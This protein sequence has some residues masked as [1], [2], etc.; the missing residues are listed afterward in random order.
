MTASSNLWSPPRRREW[1]W[2]WPYVIRLSNATTDVFGPPVP[3]EKVRSSSSRSPRRLP[4][5]TCAR[6]ALTSRPRA[7]GVRWV[8]TLAPLSAPSQDEDR[9]RSATPFLHFCPKPGIRPKWP[10]QESPSRCSGSPRASGRLLP[11]TPARR[12]DTSRVSPAKPRSTSGC[13]APARST[14]CVHRATR[15]SARFWN[16]Q[17]RPA[18][19][20][21]ASFRRHCAAMRKTIAVVLIILALCAGYVVWPYASLIGVVRAAKAGDV[22]QLQQRV[23]FRALRRSLSYQVFETYAR[24]TGTRIDPAGI[25]IA[26]ATSFIDPM[27]EK[28]LS[29]A[30]LAELMRKGW[31]TEVLA[32]APAEIEGLDPNT[33]GNAWRLFLNS[34]YGIG[35]VRV[36]VP[37]SQPREKQFRVE[38]ALERWTWKLA[39]LTLPIELQE[40]L[41][42]EL[43]KQQGKDG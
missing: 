12:P 8:P 26:A 1:E 16:S 14:G 40:R 41:A 27:I 15:N 18:S 19:H 10:K 32:E 3:R 39:G 25:T 23:N 30:T 20:N 31:P 11:S 4:S 7:L 29:P 5:H 28:L 6:P 38:L 9:G 36:T 2:A 34:D 13:P 33:L 43:M 42:R 21:S 22:S 35:E 24:L 17:S 37:V